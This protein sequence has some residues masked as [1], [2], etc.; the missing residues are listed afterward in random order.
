MD[1]LAA[2]L[3]VLEEQA[4]PP[5]AVGRLKQ[6]QA[7][8]VG[9][10]PALVAAPPPPEELPSED[11]SNDIEEEANSYY[12]RIYESEQLS[13][14]QVCAGRPSRVEPT[15]ASVRGFDR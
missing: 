13:I 3:R 8:A 7:Q 10:Y 4:L 9:S 1:A 5:E 2:L 14:P 12:Q 15:R 6:L 11:F